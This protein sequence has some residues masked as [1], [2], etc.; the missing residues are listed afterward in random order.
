MTWFSFQHSVFTILPSQ[1]VDNYDTRSDWYVERVP[2]ILFKQENQE[3]WYTLPMCWTSLKDMPPADL[4][5]VVFGLF[6]PKMNWSTN[7]PS[8]SPLSSGMDI[9]K[10]NLC[11]FYWLQMLPSPNANKHHSNNIVYVFNIIFSLFL[12]QLSFNDL[13]SHQTYNNTLVVTVIS[14]SSKT[15]WPQVIITV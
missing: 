14:H 7:P 12:P 8:T 6:W 10:L 5:R 15:L 13:N 11:L 3:I 1:L 9:L 2:D 4:K